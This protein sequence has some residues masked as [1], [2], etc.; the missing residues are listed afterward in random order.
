[1][2]DLPLVIVYKPIGR[3]VAPLR[4]ACEGADLNLTVQ[5]V[6]TEQEFREIVHKE[7]VSCIVVP[8][9]SD[10]KGKDNLYKFFNLASSVLQPEDADIKILYTIDGD[11]PPWPWPTFDPRPIKNYDEKPYDVRYRDSAWTNTIDQLKSWRDRFSSERSRRSANL[12]YTIDNSAEVPFPSEAISLLRAAFK[13][14]SAISVKFP[15]QGLSG[16]IACFVQRRDINGHKCNEVFVKIFSKH[17]KANE[18]RR[19]VETIVANHFDPPKIHENR[20]YRGIGYSLIVADLT[21]GPD[22]L[23]TTFSSVILSKK[24]NKKFTERFIAE[25]IN[26][27]RERLPY[28]CKPMD[29]IDAYLNDC[30][31]RD[32]RKQKLESDNR[33]HQWFGMIT[34][35]LS[36]KDNIRHTYE[37]LGLSGTVLG[38]CHGDLHSDNILLEKRGA[39]MHHAFIDY[40]RAGWTHAIKDMITIE[41]NII[42]RGLSGIPVFEGEDKAVFW[43]YLDALHV[44]KNLAE[45]NAKSITNKP[46]LLQ[47]EKI[48]IVVE[49][50]REFSF[51]NYKVSELEYLGAAILKT[52]EMLSYGNLPHAQNTRATSYV[53]YLIDRI[54]LLATQ[55]NA[56]VAACGARSI[57]PELVL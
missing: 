22:G 33:C 23:P 13:D 54:H 48:R 57:V 53:S 46:E 17:D 47:A 49:A 42:I 51:A 11:T 45:F 37:S 39:N 18:E 29:L 12:N 55:T 41:T 7:N 40:S 24:Y 27:C 32:E 52:L 10:E 35:G 6:N 26:F 8:V 25:L 21:K 44:Q 50:V 38:V 30:L 36:L 56:E 1:M 4:Q 3:D 14:M 9:T 19:K 20:R 15:K 16:S 5:S 34:D 43:S 2:S 31:S 28:D